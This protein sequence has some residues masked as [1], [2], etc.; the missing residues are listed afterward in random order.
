MKFN[1]IA[2][3]KEFYRMLTISPQ[4]R[5]GGWDYD[6]YW[7]SKRGNDIGKNINDYQ[8]FRA[9]WVSERVNK[10]DFVLDLGCGD[11]AVI[12]KIR[13]HVEVRVIGA[14]VSQKA[15]TALSE[16]GIDGILCD[17]NDIEGSLSKVKDVDHILLLEVI[18]HYP[19]SENL[20]L[21][22]MNKVCKSLVFSIP[23][24]GYL[25]YRLRLLFGRFPAQW[26]VSPGEHLRFWT[27]RDLQ[28]WLEQLGLLESAEVDTYQGIP[29][30]NRLFPS[31]FSAGI[32]VQ[33]KKS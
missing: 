6:D 9:S 18:E 1:F 5:I 24:T 13:D 14:D 29:I 33:I 7:E 23:N 19:N 21:N 32:I 8:L 15:I 28:I 10:K 31:V 30:L 26:R 25:P 11:G 16:V 4:V 17:L 3:I 22:C 12:K 27:L 20:L 2:S